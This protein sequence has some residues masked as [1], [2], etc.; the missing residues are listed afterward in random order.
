[1]ENT[2]RMKARQNGSD[3]NSRE[4][5]ELHR[6]GGTYDNNKEVVH[7]ELRDDLY[8]SRQNLRGNSSKQ[9]VCFVIFDACITS[10]AKVFTKKRAEE[11]F[12]RWQETQD[13]KLL[14][15]EWF[16][17][18]VSDENDNWVVMI[19]WVLAEKHNVSE[20]I[21]KA[22][23]SLAL[24]LNEHLKANG[25]WESFNPSDGSDPEGVYFQPWRPERRDKVVEALPPR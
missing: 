3:V 4:F 10:S 11:L 22:L 7:Y 14:K 20:D 19:E 17:V 8:A 18:K 25:V 24:F 2:T 23:D 1:M 6:K 12:E 15:H 9:E 5:D 16:G 13:G 21:L